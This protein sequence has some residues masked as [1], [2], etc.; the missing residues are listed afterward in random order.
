[1][2]TS[3]YLMRGKRNDNSEWMVWESP[4]PDTL[5]LYAPVPLLPGSALVIQQTSG[6][7]P[8][9]LPVPWTAVLA[10]VTLT[11]LD[12]K[13]ATLLQVAPLGAGTTTY[14]FTVFTALRDLSLAYAWK[15]LAVVTSD[16]VGTVLLHDVVVTPT[17]PGA[18]VSIA[19]SLNTG[20]LLIAVTGAIGDTYDWTIRG[21]VSYNAPGV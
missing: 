4:A 3:V 5:G 9:S 1:V 12:D 18:P 14:D 19:L 21:A 8:A 7:T 16:G 6:P 2:T 20:E 17:D 15:V 13:P 11:T 10:A